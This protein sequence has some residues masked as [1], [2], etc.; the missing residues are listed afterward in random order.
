LH[1]LWAAGAGCFGLDIGPKTAQLFAEAVMGC[2]TLFW[3]GPMGRFEVPGF[4]AG[5]EAIARAMSTATD[6]GATT[7]VGGGLRQ[8]LS[9]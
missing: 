2:R 1:L 6:A 4:A 3:N 7:V 8:R 5:T 9:L